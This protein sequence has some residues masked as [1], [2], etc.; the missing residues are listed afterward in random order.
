M[1]LPSDTRTPLATKDT[2]TVVG[3]GSIGVSWAVVFA[4]SGHTVRLHDIADERR[5]LAVADVASRLR[6]LDQAELLPESI[7]TV[8]ARISIHAT[9]QEAVEGSVYVQECVIEDLDV[10]RE[11][12]ATLDAITPRDVV[13]ASSSSTF[14]ASRF[15]DHL[16]GRERCLVVHPANPPYFLRIAEIVPA[17]FTSSRAVDVASSLLVSSDMIPILLGREVEGFVFNRLQGALLREAYCLVRDNV[18]TPVE[19]DTLVRE[20]LGLRWS[21]IGPFTTSELNTRGGLRHHARVLGPIYARLGLERGGENPWSAE[22][23][24]QVAAAIESALP[25]DSWEE[26]VRERDRGMMQLAAALRHFDNPFA[27]PLKRP[28]N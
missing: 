7:E 12:F 10:K 23:T 3:A 26:N 17:P 20:G 24:E 5:E 2:V 28:P 16:P 21:L 11:L 15:A 4:I 1:P 27:G 19:L 18:V 14:V 6:S 25:H 8:L 22:T 9:L 13:L